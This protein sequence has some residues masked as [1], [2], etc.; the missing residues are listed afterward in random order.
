MGSEKEF[1]PNPNMY[2]GWHPSLE[3]NKKK[4]CSCP[5]AQIEYSPGTYLYFCLECK[6]INFKPLNIPPGGGG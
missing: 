5:G 1:K 2:V 4:A 6:G 3:E